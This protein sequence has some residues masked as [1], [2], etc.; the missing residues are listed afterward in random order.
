MR[1]DSERE[2][3][4]KSGKGKVSSKGGM[5]LVKVRRLDSPP[6]I[7]KPKRIHA[8]RLLPFVAEGEERGVHSLSPR[9]LIARREDEAP[10]IQVTLNS[11]LSQPGQNKTASNV[12]EPSVS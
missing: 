10:D 12:G 2:S 6:K 1:Q 5:Q 3:R 4:S 9:A 8:R 11:P 7:T